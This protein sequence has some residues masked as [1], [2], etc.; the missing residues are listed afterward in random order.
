MMFRILDGNDVNVLGGDVSYLNP[1]VRL[2]GAPLP[3]EKSPR[4]LEPGESTRMV[5]RMSGTAPAVYRVLRVDS[6]EAGR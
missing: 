1:Y 5:Y 4:D 3:G 2:Y 6:G